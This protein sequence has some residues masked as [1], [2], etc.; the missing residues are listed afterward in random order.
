MPLLPAERHHRLSPRPMPPSSTTI[1]HRRANIFHVLAPNFICLSW[2][3]S[4]NTAS[5]TLS[6]HL[7][8]LVEAYDVAASTVYNHRRGREL[9]QSS[10]KRV[11]TQRPIVKDI[12]V[13][14][15]ISFFL[16][17]HPL[18]PT[19]ASTIADRARLDRET[20]DDRAFIFHPSMTHPL[21]DYWR[22]PLAKCRCNFTTGD[23]V[24]IIHV[25]VAT[26]SCW[27]PARW[28]TDDRAFVFH[29][30]M[31]HP[32]QDYW[33]L[34]PAKCR[35]NFTTGDLVIV[36]HVVV[37]T[38]SRRRPVRWAPWYWFIIWFGFC[39]NLN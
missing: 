25:V 19:M 10:P 3:F 23:L 37:A 18:R 12:G 28:A 26:Q 36:V 16:S 5:S 14:T 8:D 24:I 7:S 6:S 15:R 9:S 11:R 22:S 2:L 17:R 38:Q 4:M 13:T 30:P 29:P 33:R 39:L 31:T 21:Q 27:R 1:G 32:L 35:C 20:T 34:L